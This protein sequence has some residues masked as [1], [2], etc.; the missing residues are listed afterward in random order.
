MPHEYAKLKIYP[1]KLMIKSLASQIIENVTQ[2]DI[3]QSR[4]PPVT[5]LIN[6]FV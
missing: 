4:Y 6:L 1:P 3:T 5:C 2:I